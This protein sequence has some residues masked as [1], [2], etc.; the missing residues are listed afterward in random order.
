M[1]VFNSL[2]EHQVECQLGDVGSRDNIDIHHF[3]HVVRA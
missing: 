1:T 2:L 3:P